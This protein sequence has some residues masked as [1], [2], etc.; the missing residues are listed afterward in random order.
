MPDHVADIAELKCGK[1]DETLVMRKILF[2]YLGR[3]YSHEA[4]CCPK[5]GKAYI[6][7]EL[8]EGRMSEVERMLE[9]K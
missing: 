9:D 3:S 6:S 2:E 7:Y 8:A 5:C 4:P 1:C